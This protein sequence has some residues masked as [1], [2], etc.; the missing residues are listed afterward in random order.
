MR[1]TGPTIYEL[2][3]NAAAAMF[4]IGYD[5]SAIPP[6][7]SRP[8]VAP[9]ET[10]PE[11]IGGFLEELILLGREEGI[12]WSQAVID[13]CEVGGVQGSAAGRFLS[14]VVR[15]GPVAVSVASVDPVVEVPAGF[16]TEMVLATDAGLHAV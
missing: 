1:V 8:L 16:W 2:V 13:R 7:Y 3:E 4:S 9:G 6:T 11:L 15:H 12:V 5:L 10:I 14:E